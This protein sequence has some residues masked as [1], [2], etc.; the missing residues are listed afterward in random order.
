MERRIYQYLITLTTLVIVITSFILSLIFFDIHNRNLGSEI[1]LSSFL[2]M[3]LPVTIGILVLVLV[4]LYLISSKLTSK[5]LEPI[6]MAADNIESILSGEE[7]KSVES[8]DELM[9]FLETIKHQ[10]IQIESSI[11]KLKETE[12]YRK[13]FAANVSHELKTPLTSINGYAEMLANGMTKEEDIIRF[14]NIILKEGNRLLELID[15]IINLSKLDNMRSSRLNEPMEEMDLFKIA[16]SLVSSF[17]DRA[18][19]SDISINLY[20]ETTVI[21]G[22]RRMIEDLL[23][24]LIEN[25]IKYNIRNGRVD[26]T[27][28][29]GDKHSSIEVKDTGVGIPQVDIERVFE[30]FYR[31]DKS[32]SKRINGTGIGLSIV[33]HIV[34]YHKGKITLDSKVNIGT[35]IKIILPNK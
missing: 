12:K 27:I 8:Y 31:V 28:S 1:S 25:G 35:E 32:R 19:L 3:T 11:T 7:I 29:K 34:E 10:K 22:N 20:G 4:S 15:N 17:E 9:P 30:R 14:A 26:I 6:H 13:E 21:K 18:R 5:V 33:K 24:N 16:K 23:S 2:L